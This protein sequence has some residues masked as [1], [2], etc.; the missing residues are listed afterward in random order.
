LEK[1]LNTKLI[2]RH[3][4]EAEWLESDYIPEVNEPI[5]YDIEVNENGEKL[6]LPDG[7]STPYTYQRFKMGDGIH[8][9]KDLPFST[10]KGDWN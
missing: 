5:V 9:A 3:K 10:P 8:L 2:L 7:R 6:Q 1:I 4:L